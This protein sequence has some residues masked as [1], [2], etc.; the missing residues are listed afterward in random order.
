MD[1]CQYAAGDAGGAATLRWG[2]AVPP[3]SQM[4]K[5]WESEGFVSP[6]AARALL[7]E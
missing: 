4:R 6:D 2:H 1:N 3:S 5:E 7:D